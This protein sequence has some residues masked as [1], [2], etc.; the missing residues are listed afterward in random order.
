[1]NVVSRIQ[2]N[3]WRLTMSPS[4]ENDERPVNIQISGNLGS[5]GNTRSNVGNYQ[6]LG[7]R[8]EHCIP[9]MV[10]MT[11]PRHHVAFGIRPR[12]AAAS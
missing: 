5:D 2:N 1:M 11:I 8:F 7:G 4:V 6:H 9:M 12:T 3:V 10:E